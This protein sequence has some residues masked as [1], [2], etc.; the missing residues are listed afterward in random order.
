MKLIRQK[1]PPRIPSTNLTLV[2]TGRS[3][4]SV[5]HADNAQVANSMEA[6]QEAL[7]K[8]A[9]AFVRKGNKLV[10][11]GARRFLANLKYR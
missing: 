6:T 1:A 8:T 2:N 7:K 9:D 5:Q 11:V 4:A 10:R 3:A